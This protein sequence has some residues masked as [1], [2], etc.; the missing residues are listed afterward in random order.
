MSLNG[1]K[2]DLHDRLWNAQQRWFA[3]RGAGQVSKFDMKKAGIRE[4]RDPNHYLRPLLFTGRTRTTYERV[5]KCFVE[6]AHARFGVQKFDDIDTKHGKA[7]LDD[8]IQ[9]GLAAKTLHVYRS[10]LAKG[11]ALIGKTASGESLS[12]KFGARIRDLVVAGA[13]PGPA[14]V[15]PSH[16]VVERA[17][18]ILRDW[19]AR[20]FERTGEP[21]AYHLA[22]LLQLETAA[23][24]V[25]VT[26]RLTKDCLKGD[27]HLDVIGKGGQVIL[28]QVTPGLYA[29]I[30]EHLGNSGRTLADLRGYQAAWRR[31]VVATGGRTT[32]THGLRRLS[33]QEFYREKYAQLL[34]NGSS[35]EEARQEA[36]Q[37]AVQ[38]LGHSRD[39]G[40][41]AVC[42]LGS[43]A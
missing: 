40:D 31:A 34:A 25:S 17:I 43:A 38:R 14:R 21:R 9:R 32:G 5:L 6:F 12:R 18:D 22:A 19:D 15:T 3:M 37:E 20:H 30:S 2:R 35:P 10:A 26:D 8:A 33:T 28:T 1:M 13:I 42:Y 39:R 7:F 23:R 36:R 29:A 16:A 41:Q 4:F 11:F 27:S 24:G